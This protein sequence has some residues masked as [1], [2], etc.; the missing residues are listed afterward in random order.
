MNS[1][2]T[3]LLF[4]ATLLATSQA[5][6]MGTARRFGMGMGGRRFGDVLQTLTT[7]QKGRFMEMMMETRNLPK[8]QAKARFDQFAATVNPEARAMMAAGKAR[9]EKM[10]AD[11]DRKAGGLSASAKAV[12]NQINAVMMDQ[13]LSYAESHKRMM[14]LLQQNPS[15]LNEMKAA[16]MRAPGMHMGRGRGGDMDGGDNQFRRVFRR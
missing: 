4:S 7:E 12:Y 2:T 10:K 11:N 14:A 15:A 13:S 3:A 16:G 5:P 9:M 6:G 1:L 8:G